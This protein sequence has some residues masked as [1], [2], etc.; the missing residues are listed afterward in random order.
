MR[1]LFFLS[2]SFLQYLCRRRR[3]WENLWQLKIKTILLNLWSKSL[4]SNQTK[5]KKQ[6]KDFKKDLVTQVNPPK[7]EKAE[8]MSNLTYLND[9]SVL[10]NLK[11]RY[12]H[13]L[14]YV[15]YRIEEHQ[16]PKHGFC[17]CFRFCFVFV[18][19][20][21]SCS[22]YPDNHNPNLPGLVL[23]TPNT[24]IVKLN[25]S[26]SFFVKFVIT[27]QIK[28]NKI[29]SQAHTNKKTNQHNN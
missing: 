26:K 6:T 25:T 21:R 29:N 24:I 2:L 9:A 1:S 4:L 15:S 22:S 17:F 19:N 13:K 14:I 28:I 11:Q 3:R 10:H 5:K 20:D 12:Y 23:R 27:K 7:Y 18:W 8:D 16:Q